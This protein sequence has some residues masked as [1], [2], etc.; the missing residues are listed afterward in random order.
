MQ[1]EGLGAITPRLLG[2]GPS[3]K[4][5]GTTHPIRDFH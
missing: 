3:D 1:L 5:D 4:T 2:D